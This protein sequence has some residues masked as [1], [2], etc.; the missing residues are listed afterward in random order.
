MT[1]ARIK[2]IRY[3]EE[4]CLQIILQ[5]ESMLEYDMESKLVTARF[6][7]LEDIRVFQNGQIAEAGRMIRWNSNTEI[8]IEEILMQAKEY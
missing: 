5:D 6:R 8:S 3:K 7:D 2:E 4:Y 1:A